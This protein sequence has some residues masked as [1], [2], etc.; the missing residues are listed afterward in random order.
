MNSHLVSTVVLPRASVHTGPE[1]QPF[2][3]WAQLDEANRV[4]EG[5]GGLRHLG[6]KA[7]V[8]HRGQ[9]PGCPSE[10]SLG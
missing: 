4:T 7:T 8:D 6:E 3:C 5:R 2:P 9:D 10:H 1:T